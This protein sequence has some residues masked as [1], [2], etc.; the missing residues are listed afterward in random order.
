MLVFSSA[1]FSPPP[2]VTTCATWPPFGRRMMRSIVPGYFASAAA[3]TFAAV[4]P[5]TGRPKPAGGPPGQPARALDGVLELELDASA[6]AEAPNAM[7]ASAATPATD[8]KMVFDM[9]DL[10]TS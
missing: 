8:F 10:S 1:C 3:L 5:V 7:A 2:L 6:I 4:V 9:G